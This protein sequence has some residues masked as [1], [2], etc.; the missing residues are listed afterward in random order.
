MN[1]SQK[2]MSIKL[3]AILLLLVLPVLTWASGSP[4]VRSVPEWRM[5]QPI[6]EN[7][8]LE[9][10]KRLWAMGARGAVIQA[11]GV[12]EFERGYYF[13]IENWESVHIS[14]QGNAVFLHD[15]QML[16]YIQS[17]HKAGVGVVLH[18]RMVVGGFALTYD[19]D[20][21]QLFASSMPKMAHQ[22]FIVINPWTDVYLLNHEV[23]HND[24][25]RSGMATKLWQEILY[26]YSGQGRL[27]TE[28][29]ETL[30][31]YIIEARAYLQELRFLLNFRRPIEWGG[32]DF[33]NPDWTP[34]GML[35]GEVF[36]AIRVNALIE[37]FNTSYASSMRALPASVRSRAID[38][39]SEN[40]PDYFQ[41]FD[42]Q[43]RLRAAA[44]TCSSFLLVNS[45]S[46]D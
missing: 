29:L 25:H 42:S 11:K 6:L 5:T 36:R 12:H 7:D 32:L 44:E 39:L 35:S 33:N 22:P 41:R 40:I 43:Y 46:F 19:N 14:R 3:P 17:L 34:V 15:S 27:R 2:W 9:I 20:L 1:F 45:P 23:I 21:F 13:A 38:L 37:T 31:F 26:R 24:D 10:F 8:P 18:N 4:L 16:E 28:Q 30:Y